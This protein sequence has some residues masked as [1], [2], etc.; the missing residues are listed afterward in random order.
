MIETWRP[1]VGI[2]SFEVSDIGN[3]RHVSGS[4]RKLIL[5]KT[6]HLSASLAGKRLYVH[7]LVMFAFGP[8]PPASGLV[9]RHLN[10]IPSDN[11]LAN[12]AWGTK[13]DNA[14]DATANGLNPLGERRP[15]AK[16]SFEL[17]ASLRARAAAGERY[18]D[19]AREVGAHWSSVRNAILGT[20]YKN[21]T[22][23]NRAG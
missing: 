11:R 15:N 20:T 22:T 2:P 18:A 17:V 19:L 12:L 23:E 6:G 4:P 8:P 7:R 10:D 9:V 5:Q 16:L 3:V 13:S 14:L 21:H 1:V